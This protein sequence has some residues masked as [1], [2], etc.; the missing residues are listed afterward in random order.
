MENLGKN[1]TDCSDECHSA[2][3]VIII[4]TSIVMAIGIPGNSIVIRVFLAKHDKS[5]THMLILALAFVDLVSCFTT[6]PFMLVSCPNSQTICRLQFL[7]TVPCILTSLLITTT[8]AIERYFATCRPY[9]FK[10]IITASRT[11]MI[12]CLCVLI[13]VLFSIIFTLII[14]FVF[15]DCIAMSKMDHWF[16]N[17]LLVL[18]F[19]TFT[20]CSI[21]VLV[22]YIRIFRTLRQ[23]HKFAAIL[24]GEAKADSFTQK[25]LKK[26]TTITKVLHALHPT[27]GIDVPVDTS[28][29][30][31]TTST[32]PEAGP[33]KIDTSE[34]CIHLLKTSNKIEVRSAIR[35][36]LANGNPIDR[37]MEK[38]NS[39]EILLKE[40]YVLNKSLRENP[41]LS[42]PT[43][44]YNISTPPECI[45]L[46]PIENSLSTRSESILP[47]SS[48]KPSP[49]EGASSSWE[50]TSIGR[51]SVTQ[52]DYPHKSVTLPG[53]A[54]TDEHG[55]YD[56]GP[57]VTNSNEQ[58]TNQKHW[59]EIGG[60]IDENLSATRCD[61]DA[62]D[63]TQHYASEEKNGL[64]PVGESTMK[65]SDTQ[66]NS[67]MMLRSMIKKKI[68]QK[69]KR[70]TELITLETAHSSCTIRR[71]GD[72][73]K[74]RTTSMLLIVSMIFIVTWLSFWICSIIEY[75]TDSLN[76]DPT[77]MC[78][79]RLY[80]INTACNP[81]VYSFLNSRFR[82]DCA[83]TLR[84]F[85]YFQRFRVYIGSKFF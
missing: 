39:K 18:Y 54:E 43:P 78:F 41:A 56:I 44:K 16:P 36:E 74:Q 60:L 27:R 6:L 26:V 28:S 51:Q 13:P 72:T 46:N 84:L 20:L 64:N 29:I 47:A 19:I 7:F 62:T 34:K 37:S 24:K 70:Q 66:V 73:R 14:T 45:I 63:G 1:Y 17:G 9:E 83:S 81:I 77:F 8:I 58:Q 68:T 3:T 53:S 22:L 35:H 32:P 50:L 33:S 57:L 61:V 76:T 31:Q 80:I 4:F 38:R 11:K 82:K 15:E 65:Q 42:P 52:A 75:V 5:T 21:T 85:Q 59:I 23:Q 55:H 12:I 25:K 67:I 2:H 30:T 69:N 48:V 49:G 10:K 71:N 40:S 79:K